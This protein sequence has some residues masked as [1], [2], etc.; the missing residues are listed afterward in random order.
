MS[1]L[2]KAFSQTSIGIQAAEGTGLGLS[3][4]RRFAQMM[5]GD[6]H[7]ESQVGRGTTFTLEV[8]CNVVS[9]PAIQS[10]AHGPQV[11][12]LEPGQ[13]PYRILVVDDIWE[14]RQLLVRLLEPLGFIMREAEN[15]E[16]AV[17]IAQS[18]RP[19]L[20]WMDIY[21]PIIDG[22]EAVQQIRAAS[23]GQSMKIVALTASVGEEDSARVMS[24]GCDDG[25]WSCIVCCL[26]MWYELLLKAVCYFVSCVNVVVCAING[27]GIIWDGFIDF[28]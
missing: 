5:G 24:S 2:F 26:W 28:L 22:I 21:M 19:H 7:V 25:C 13:P 20:I 18:F 9:Q 16:E 27:F 23:W 11:I 3:I 6:I 17:A 12:G 1:D 4:S 8:A 15:G 10:V 14:N